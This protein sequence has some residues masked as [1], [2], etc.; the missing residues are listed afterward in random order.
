MAINFSAPP[1]ET[2]E[3]GSKQAIDAGP[4]DTLMPNESATVQFRI[5]LANRSRFRVLCGC[6][7]AS[8]VSAMT[9]GGVMPQE[10]DACSPWN[11]GSVLTLR[12]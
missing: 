8:S 6:I 1:K 7:G 11:S 10:E 3:S 4:D 2:E 5:G 12:W 9:I